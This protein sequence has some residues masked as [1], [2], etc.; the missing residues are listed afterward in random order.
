MNFFLK[1]ITLFSFFIFVNY[2]SFSQDNFIFVKGGFYRPGN[3]T[4]QKDEQNAKK[5]YLKSFYLQESEVTNSQF[6]KFLNDV[7]NKQIGNT[8]YINLKGKWRTMNCRIYKD[9]NG[10]FKTEKGF[11]DFP[12]NFVSW[13][14]ADAY[15]K[16]YGGRLPTEI[17][18]EYAAGGG[19][20][21]KNNYLY[22]GGNE[23]DSIAFYIE[24]SEN[25]LHKVKSKKPNTIKLFDMTGNLAEWCDNWYKPDE[26]KNLKRFSP[27]KKSKGQF[28]SHRGG[29]WTDSKKIIYYKNRR[30]SNP[31]T[32]RST[33]G[34]RMLKEK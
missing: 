32:T 30:A 33:I 28:K 9:E 14:G 19:K 11:E 3:K 5:A 15:C 7:G 1:L 16:H 6:C 23:I 10:I 31:E 8:F 20:I 29:S 27:M 4:G 25:K 24:N 12:V 2:N 34:F 18:W 13:Y 26:Y 22:S 17:E 21:S